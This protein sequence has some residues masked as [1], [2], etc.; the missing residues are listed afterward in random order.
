MA[1]VPTTANFLVRH[2]SETN[3]EKELKASGTTTQQSQR[4]KFKLNSSVRAQQSGS[5]RGG[6]RFRFNSNWIWF[7]V[8]FWKLGYTMV[9]P[10]DP[11][12]ILIWKMIS[13]GLG[14]SLLKPID[15]ANWFLLI[16]PS[17]MD[18]VIYQSHIFWGLSWQNLWKMISPIS[19][20]PRLVFQVS[21]SFREATFLRPQ[22]WSQRGAELS[23]AAVKL[24]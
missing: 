6:I 21:W 17:P 19:N 13:I 18:Y 1:S 12:A 16:S 4:I 23:C 7:P 9:Y 11:I 24:R 22:G 15:K 3:I 20:L 8:L 10:I 2:L 5:Q 14:D